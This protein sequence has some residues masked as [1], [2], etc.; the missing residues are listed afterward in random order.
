MEEYTSPPVSPLSEIDRAHLPTDSMVT[1]RLSDIPEPQE[2]DYDAAE[3]FEKND[4]STVETRRASVDS[5][6]SNVSERSDQSSDASVDWEGLEKTE[7]QEPRS[8]GTDDVR[9]ASKLF[10]AH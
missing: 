7:E 6:L 9:S 5:E 10:C 4:Q 2:L 1:V 3:K 8:E